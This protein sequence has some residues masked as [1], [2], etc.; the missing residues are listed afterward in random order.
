MKVIRFDKSGPASVLTIAEAQESEPKS[1]EIKIKIKA[2]GLNHLDIWLREGKVKV[3]SL[4]WIPGCDAAG[5]VVE[6]G[7][8]VKAFK[9]GD[10]VFVVPGVSC[11]GCDFCRQKMENFC[12]TF[13]I[14]GAMIPGSH[15]EY[16]CPP[17][18]QA[19]HLPANLGFNEGAAFPLTFLTAW[20]MLAS[21]ARIQKNE[22][23]LIMAGA[24][25]LGT[26]AIQIA[27][28]LGAKVIT[29]VGDASRT[30]SLKDLGAHEV[31]HHY[32]ENIQEEMMEITANR[33][34]DVIFDHVGARVWPA[35]LTSLAKGGRMVF[36]GTTTGGDVALNLRNIFSR[37]Q[38][39]MGCTMGNGQDLLEVTKHIA[40][41]ALKPLVHKVFPFTEIQ[42]AHQML[43][44]GGIFGKIILQWEK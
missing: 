6:V 12:A 31:I 43:E 35:L 8:H 24:S 29:T 26:A 19:L 39:L 10:R 4:P 27:K 23:V 16:L 34:V 17:E 37:Q 42:K 13:Q 32:Q 1:G 33:G 30:E 20:H 2:S 11:G 14:R 36:C 3:P 7:L 38:T 21:R 25:G 41:G 5:V 22:T 44:N 15:Q 28:L 18:D 40:S 9:T